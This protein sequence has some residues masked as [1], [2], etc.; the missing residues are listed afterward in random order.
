[1]QLRMTLR[2][3]AA[4]GGGGVDLN[5]MVTRCCRMQQAQHVEQNTLPILPKPYCSPPTIV[6]QIMAP[7]QP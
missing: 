4:V 1:M 3:S 5:A 7:T 6:S 2:S